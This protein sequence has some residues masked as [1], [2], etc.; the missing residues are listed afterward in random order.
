MFTRCTK[1]PEM[2]R[3]LVDNDFVD[4]VVSSDSS[5]GGTDGGE[6]RSDGRGLTSDSQ[7]IYKMIQIASNM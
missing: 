6:R 4:R 3:K 7:Q 5:M 2:A 1:L